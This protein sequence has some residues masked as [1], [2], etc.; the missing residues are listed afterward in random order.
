M[1]EDPAFAQKVRLRYQTLRPN[2]LKTENLHRYIDSTA[3]VLQDAR[4]R[5]F[6]RWP[7]IGQ[8]IWPNFYVGA[9]YE[10]EVAYLKTYI[11]R[12]LEWMDQAIAT[13][14]V[15]ITA[16]EPP[17][18]PFEFKVF[19]NPASEKVQISFNLSSASVVKVQAYDL[20]GRILQET[21]LGRLAPGTHQVTE[22]LPESGKGVEFLG[23][24]IDGKR[25]AVRRV[26]RE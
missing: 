13:I 23:L 1:L 11:T 24:E 7:V 10:D 9:T 21:L 3:L 15:P 18:V 16:I 6:T 17:I 4:V 2:V 20:W 12:R 19:P 25:A 26:L 14:G 5:N 22:N 8:N